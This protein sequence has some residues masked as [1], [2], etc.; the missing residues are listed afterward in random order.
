MRLRTC[1]SALLVAT[2]LAGCDGA[3]S[4]TTRNT[5]VEDSRPELSPPGQ[6]APRLEG[7]N[8]GERPLNLADYRGKVVL[9]TFW[10]TACPPCRAF[11]RH[12]RALALRYKDKPFAL[13]GV[14][15]DPNAEICRRTQETEGMFWP[16]LVDGQ[17]AMLDWGVSGTPTIFLIDARGEVRY[18]SIG[19][20]DEADLRRLIDA[21][22]AEIK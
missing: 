17:E 21:L 1:A 5:T 7:I 10:Q 9:L 14:N 18:N 22:L 12:E 3:V 16:S 19:A 15:S 11:H 6:P 4:P 20:P 2:L 8:S 13:L